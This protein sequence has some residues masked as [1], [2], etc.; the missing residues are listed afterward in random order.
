M[1][2]R[3]VEQVKVYYLIMNPVTDRAESGRIT[4]MS[5]D[6]NTLISAYKNENVS[7]YDDG[8]YRKVF[9]QGGPLEWYNPLWTIEGVDSFGHGLSEDWVD[10]ENLQTLKNKYYFI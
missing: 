3:L 10:M 6:K 9:R 5:T 2:T 1:E 8:N 4:M 7:T